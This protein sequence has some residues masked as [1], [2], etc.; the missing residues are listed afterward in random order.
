MISP[1][2]DM[3][4][5]RVFKWVIFGLVIVFAAAMTG[6]LLL[7]VRSSK[8]LS[9]A[10]DRIE[11][12]NEELIQVPMLVAE[13]DTAD[14][15]DRDAGSVVVS[16]RECFDPGDGV[17]SGLT[18]A[19]IT[20]IRWTW[21]GD[22]ADGITPFH[23]EDGGATNFGEKGARTELD[24]ENCFQFEFPQPFPTPLV[25]N[26]ASQPDFN[27]TMN[28][29]FVITPIDTT[30][31]QSVPGDLVIVDSGDFVVPAIPVTAR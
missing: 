10:E 28:L 30:S 21:V 6:I 2:N 25:R 4:P 18:F 29:T 12:L 7:A 19:T 26:L 11:V 14:I 3:G 8:S 23:N 9:V 27:S 20:T 16:G 22:V 5:T 24:A 31:G 1:V 15:A 17:E 13:F